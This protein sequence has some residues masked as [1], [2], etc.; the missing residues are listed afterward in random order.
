MIKEPFYLSETCPKSVK[1]LLL[2]TTLGTNGAK[3]QHL[4]TEQRINDL[5]NPLY[6]G[7]ERNKKALGNITFCRR[8]RNWYIRFFAFDSLFQSASSSSTQKKT[9]RLKDTI[10]AFFEQRLVNEVDCFYAYIDPKNSRS[11]AMSERFDFHTIGS[12]KTQSFSR[13]YP[14]KQLKLNSS[15]EPEFMTEV[16][17]SS[18]KT[19]RFFKPVFASNSILYYIKDENNS[20]IAHASVLPVRWKIKRI[21]GKFGAFLT[22]ALPYIPF[23]NKLIHPQDYRFLALD[24]CYINPAYSSL[25]SDFLESILYAEKQHVIFWWVDVNDPNYKQIKKQTNWGLL[26][27]ILDTPTVSVVCKGKQPENKTPIYVSSVD[28]V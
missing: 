7:L 19:Y 24:S 22:K 1:N 15:N 26:H 14:K 2:G 11:L 12:L 23:L 21:P 3:Y 16:L 8:D 27:K 13:L 28:L 5:D 18:F 17:S 6:F 20:I 25:F 9:S 4:D 10:D